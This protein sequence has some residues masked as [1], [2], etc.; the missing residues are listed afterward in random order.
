MV[1]KE[2]R[3]WRGATIR[4]VDDSIK[5]FTEEDLF[6][7]AEKYKNELQKVGSGM[8][9]IMHAATYAGNRSILIAKLLHCQPD[10]LKWI[11]INLRPKFGF[12]TGEI[13]IT[14]EPEILVRKDGVFI[15]SWSGGYHDDI[16]YY[17]VC[18]K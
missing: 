5:V 18:K 3:K 6:V 9:G 8:G 16:K 14:F 15:S 13:T 10:E 11:K 1:F 17:F 12:K 7:I 4:V 2:I